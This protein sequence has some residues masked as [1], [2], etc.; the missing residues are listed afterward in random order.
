MSFNNN[1]DNAESSMSLSRQP[2]AMSYLLEN[3]DN[4][5]QLSEISTTRA[6]SR[7]GSMAV[8]QDTQESSSV[9]MEADTAT[10]PKR[11]RNWMVENK[12][13][14]MKKLHDGRKEFRC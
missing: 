1:I 5:D 2:S 13:M 3:S 11:K 14:I 8:D 12:W 7:Q 6:L 10:G 4:E 9:I